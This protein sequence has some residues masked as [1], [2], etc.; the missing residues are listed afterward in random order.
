[1]VADPKACEEIE[2]EAETLCT[3]EEKD[4]TIEEKDKA[5]EEKDKRITEL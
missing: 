2:K 4:K 5:L 1:M 3:I